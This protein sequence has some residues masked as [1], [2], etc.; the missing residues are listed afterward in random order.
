MRI[1]S[2]LKAF[3]SV[4]WSSSLSSWKGG[5]A[6][7][8][9]SGWG[10]ASV[11]SSGW[12]MG[13]MDRRGFYVKKRPVEE[14]NAIQE[15]SSIINSNPAFAIDLFEQLNRG[16]RDA[17]SRKIFRDYIKKRQVCL[18]LFLFLFLGL[19]LIPK[20]KMPPDLVLKEFCKIL[21]R[22]PDIEFRKADR[23]Q[24]GLV[25]DTELKEWSSS[26]LM[27]SRTEDAPTKTQPLTPKQKYAVFVNQTVPFIGFGFM[28]NAIMILAGDKIDMTLGLSLGLSTMAAAGLGNL[29][30]D[31]CGIGFGGSLF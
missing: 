12:G 31:V 30:S 4:W 1:S 14:E 6:S 17:I 2:G 19:F 9:S 13:R 27:K 29:L 7:I 3:G 24:D 10:V 5:V 22:D 16:G 8:P 11:S 25:T 21:G 15:C 28:D 18:F 26:I 20:P 23:D